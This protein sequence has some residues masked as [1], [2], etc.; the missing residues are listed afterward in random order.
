[1]GLADGTRRLAAVPGGSGVVGALLRAAAKEL[2]I[3]ADTLREKDGMKERV[4]SRL[5]R[6]E[7]AEGRRTARGTGVLATIGA[8]APRN[9]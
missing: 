3:S 1:M 8:T 4:A 6:I 5:E 9:W 7:A 2:R